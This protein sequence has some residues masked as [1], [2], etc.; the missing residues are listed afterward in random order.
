MKLKQLIAVALIIAILGLLLV[1]C[2]SENAKQ[3]NRENKKEQK[4][5]EEKIENEDSKLQG[6]EEVEEGNKK[7]GLDKNK[8]VRRERSAS[9]HIPDKKGASHK[10]PFKKGRSKIMNGEVKLDYNEEGK[11]S[12]ITF[13][14]IEE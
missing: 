14:I 12:K 6:Q 13:Q 9:I 4:P 11:V 8:R 1:G 7:V 5:S 2:A 3:Q 10:T